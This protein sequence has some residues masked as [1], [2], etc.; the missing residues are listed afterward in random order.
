MECCINEETVAYGAR[1]TVGKQTCIWN[2]CPSG[3]TECGSSF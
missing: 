3:T 2:P 1:C